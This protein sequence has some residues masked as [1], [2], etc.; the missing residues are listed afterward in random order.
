MK[1]EIDWITVELWFK[2]ELEEL[3]R[4]ERALNPDDERNPYTFRIFYVQE[5]VGSIEQGD[6]NHAYDVIVE[7]YGEGYFDEFLL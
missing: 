2:D 4:A 6:L 5:I 7:Q 3:M 1:R